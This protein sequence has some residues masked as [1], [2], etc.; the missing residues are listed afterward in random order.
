L[1]V[2]LT[3]PYVYPSVIGGAENYVYYLARS[4]R[5]LGLDVIVIASEPPDA[6]VKIPSRDL[7]VIFLKPVFRIGV[8]P[9]TPMLFEMI[10]REKPDIVHTQAPTV[11]ADLSLLSCKLLKIPIVSTYH[12]SIADSIVP[13]S[14][15]TLYNVLHHGFTLRHC[16]YIITTT[17]RYMARLRTTGLPAHKIGVVPIGI[18]KDFIEAKISTKSRNQFQRCISKLRYSPAFSI[19]F[20]GVLD[21]YHMYKGLDKLLIAF[22]MVVSKHPNSLLIVVGDGDKRR[23]YETLC[24]RLGLLRHTLFTGFVSKELL[25]ALYSFSNLFVLPSTSL[26]EGFGIVLLEAMSRGC[27]VL[28]TTYAG[29]AEIIREEDAGVVINTA[30]P[31]SLYRSIINFIDNENLAEKCGKRGLC[32][33]RQK[34]TWTALSPKVLEIYKRH[35]SIN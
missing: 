24:K 26:S 15:L 16:N 1:R 2:C 28:T 10:M 19:L 6:I 4:L 12:A 17:K 29:G 22:K 13:Y 7:R 35:T 14:L 21:R 20:V 27:P 11:T 5:K 32:A 3:S 33:V 8:N 30:D 23:F 34:Y 25:I 18:E 9:V 31:F